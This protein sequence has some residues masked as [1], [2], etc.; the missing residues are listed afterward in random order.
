[1]ALSK[2]T[3]LPGERERTTSVDWLQECEIMQ[4]YKYYITGNSS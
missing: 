3:Q 1:M 4:P 2:P